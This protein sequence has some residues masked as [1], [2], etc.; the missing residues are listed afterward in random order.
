MRRPRRERPATICSILGSSS[1]FQRQ[2][3]E[4]NNKPS[5]AYCLSSSLEHPSTHTDTLC[6][7]TFTHV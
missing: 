2:E 6:Y 1:L 5:L 3:P 4:L 7:F